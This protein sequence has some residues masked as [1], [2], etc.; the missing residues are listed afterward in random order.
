MNTIKKAATL[1]IIIIKSLITIVGVLCI[2]SMIPF[3]LFSDVSLD[4]KAVNESIRLVIACTIFCVVF[5]L[6][7]FRSTKHSIKLF[8]NNLDVDSSNKKE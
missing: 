7:C 4:Q 6:I 8:K 3:L 1:I 5:F 2:L